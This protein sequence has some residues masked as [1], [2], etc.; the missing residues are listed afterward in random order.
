[1]EK[2]KGTIVEY[3]KYNSKLNNGNLSIFSGGVFALFPEI[4]A[5]HENF[6]YEKD[7][8]K[9]YIEHQGFGYVSLSYIRSIST[10]VINPDE[11]INIQENLEELTEFWPI[12]EC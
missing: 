3:R 12:S 6:P 4:K 7:S 10:I 2:I 11:Y 8:V 5:E 9:Y 1:M